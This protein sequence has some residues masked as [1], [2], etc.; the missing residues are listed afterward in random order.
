MLVATKSNPLDNYA[1]HELLELMAIKDDEDTAKQAF[2]EFYER[3]SRFL[4]TSV[5]QVVRAYSKP[6]D[7]AKVVFNNTFLNV[8]RSAHTFKIDGRQD[9]D[10]IQKRIKGWLLVIAK[11]ELR[12]QIK[13]VSDKEKEE[14]V[15]A[16]MLR[17]AKSGSKKET[18]EEKL[19]R[20]ALEQLPKERDREIFYLYWLYYEPGDKGQG[21][22]FSKEV[23]AELCRKYNTT[24]MNL[25]QI[26]SRSKKIVFEYLRK[27]YKNVKQ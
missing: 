15:Y 18:Y 4:Y 7:W 19:V 26:V 25:R 14:E 17:N 16:A 27:T 22:S 2:H 21:K 24:D 23:A 3:Y 5:G 8:Y 9:T 10:S 12:S 20:Q 11:N 13:K 6:E 1:D